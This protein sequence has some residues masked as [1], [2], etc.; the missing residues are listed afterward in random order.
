MRLSPRT[1]TGYS[2]LCGYDFLTHFPTLIDRDR[3]LVTLF[4][5]PSK[6]AHL[7]CVPVE[8]SSK[9]ALAT[10]EI[11]GTWLNEVVLDSGMAGGGALWEGVRTRLR[12]PLVGDADYYPSTPQMSNGFTCGAT[13]SVRYAAGTAE[14]EM[15]ICTE[16]R[17]PDG[18]NGII[19][20]NLPSVHLLAID[21]PHK[22]ICFDVNEFTQAYA[23]APP[24]AKA[25]ASISEAWARFN[26]LRPPL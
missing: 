24:P 13:A 17:R 18:Y 22:R 20:T 14:T 12:Q 26:S 6:V 25:A 5:A 10:V 11:N 4:P 1:L 2:A 8:L 7:H 15:P 16:P 23:P 21:Y 9:V 3:R 19:E